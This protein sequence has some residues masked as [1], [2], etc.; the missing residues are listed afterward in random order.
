VGQGAGHEWGKAWSRSSS[1]PGRAG[2]LGR[3]CFLEHGVWYG[4]YP[5][6]PTAAECLLCMCLRMCM[7]VYTVVWL[8]R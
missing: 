1:V 7:V 8:C 6:P 5:P 3:L 4:M 2:R